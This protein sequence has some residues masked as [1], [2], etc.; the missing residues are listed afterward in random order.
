M[1]AASG[2]P[3]EDERSRADSHWSDSL[4]YGGGSRESSDPDPADEIDSEYWDRWHYGIYVAALLLLIG[5]IQWSLAPLVV[6]YLLVPITIHLDSRYLE[7][8]TPGWQR[9]TG[10][11]VLGSV[12]AP[13]LLIPMYLYRRRELGR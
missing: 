10:L 1:T 13:F 5:V 9:D 7:S 3:S 11:Y 2:E 8:V 12:L 4:S 6:G